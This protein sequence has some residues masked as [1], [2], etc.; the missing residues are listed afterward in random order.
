MAVV[1]NE[2]LQHQATIYAEEAT[3]LCLQSDARQAQYGAVAQQQAAEATRL[4]ALRQQLEAELA[5][6]STDL[7]RLKQAEVVLSAERTRTAA[8]HDRAVHEETTRQRELEASITNVNQTI[9][10]NRAAELAAVEAERQQQA[11]HL[12]QINALKHEFSLASNN[13]SHQQ[14]ELGARIAAAEASL[15]QSHL[16]TQ[17]R[18]ANTLA[19][20]HP[21]I[22]TPQVARRF[23]F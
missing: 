15:T 7:E 14:Q 8:E 23:P 3:Q 2:R 21:V 17:V 5:Q 6:R 16:G 12:D 11:A 1:V 18:E 22:Y 19:S 13:H 20:T 4:A 9:H 10:A